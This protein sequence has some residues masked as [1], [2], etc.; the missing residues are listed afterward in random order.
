MKILKNPH[1]A[2]IKSTHSF[3]HELVTN[4]LEDFDKFALSHLFTNTQAFSHKL[5]DNIWQIHM[6]FEENPQAKGV[7]S[8]AQ[9]N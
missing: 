2:G 5:T 4:P 7:D 8:L 9:F 6:Q 3:R 1:D